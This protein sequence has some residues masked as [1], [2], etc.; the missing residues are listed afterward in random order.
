MSFKER[1]NNCRK[2]DPPQDDTAITAESVITFLSRSITG[3]A[4]KLPRK[5]AAFVFRVIA[6]P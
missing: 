6:T 2:A 4:P 5:T 1:L 3:D